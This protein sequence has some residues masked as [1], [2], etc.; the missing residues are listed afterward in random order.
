METKIKEIVNWIKE[1]TKKAHADGVV[2]RISGGINSAV[3]VALAQKA[4]P[5]NIKVVWMGIDSTKY[6][7]RNCNRVLLALE[8]KE[9]KVDLKPTLDQ[10]IKD[11][12]ELELPIAKGDVETFTRKVNGEVM[13]HDMSYLKLENLDDIIENIKSRLRTAT[14]YAWAQRKNYLVLNTLSSSEIYVGEFTKWG[15]SVG[16]LAPI[17]H[18]TKSEVYELAKELELPE[19]VIETNKEY[20]EGHK[21]LNYLDVDNFMAQKEIPSDKKTLIEKLHQEA[22]LNLIGVKK[23]N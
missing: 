20:D 6:A 21:V 22:E 4:F 11:I 3:T 19:L 10:Y 12:F 15:D 5:K 23:I 2:V 8:L 14:L 7:R 17:A 18:L 13:P 1:E 9:T 16:D